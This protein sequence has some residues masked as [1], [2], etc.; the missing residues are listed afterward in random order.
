MKTLGLDDIYR[1]LGTR[2]IVGSEKE[3]KILCMRITEL[4][5]SNGEK[6]VEENRQMLLDEWDYIVRQGIIS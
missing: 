4:A 3:L 5:R 2:S 1:L 6:W